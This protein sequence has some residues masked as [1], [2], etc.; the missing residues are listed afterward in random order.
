[1]KT[2]SLNTLLVVILA[3]LLGSCK[4]DPKEP[5]N[6]NN[7]NSSNT[8]TTGK[9]ILSFEAMF[10]DSVLVFNNKTYI[11]QNGDSVNISTFKY[12]ISNIQLIKT[13]NSTYTV[14]ESYLLV[15]HNASGSMASFTLSNIPVGQYK[16]IKMLIGVDSARNVSGAQTDAL[17]PSNG[18]FWSWSTGYIMMKL[19]GTSPQVGWTSKTF[20]FHIGGF[21]GTYNVLKW[22]NPS[23]NL[24][25]ADVSSSVT[26]EIHFKTDISEIF[27]TPNTINL[28]TTFQVTTGPFAK[29]MADNYADMITVEHIHN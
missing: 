9:L 7:N 13:D 2:L 11:T 24:A 10:G 17:D 16:G 28:A 19:E 3:L 29:M 14:P 18:M 23:F 21:S 15:N 4:K 26:P 5:A 25:T 6:N 12:Y 8:S 1:M 22:I 27:K 20:Q